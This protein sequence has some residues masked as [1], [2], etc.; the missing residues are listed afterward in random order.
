MPVIFRKSEII[1]KQVEETF[2]FLADPSNMHKI[3][4]D[5]VSAEKV[6]NAPLGAGTRIK[7][8]R[9]MMNKEV[10]AE[11]KVSR[12]EPPVEFGVKSEIM[13][14]CAEYIYMFEHAEGGTKVDLEARIQ[15]HGFGKILLPLFKSS[16]KK[17]D[18]DQLQHLKKCLESDVRDGLY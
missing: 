11:V 8:T 9:K 14:I 3:M 15:A 16:M 1:S 2:E 7:E 5:V 18:S 13:G 6:G 10:T 12:Y 4:P 17:Q